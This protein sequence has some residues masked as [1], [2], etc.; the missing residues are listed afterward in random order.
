MLGESLGSVVEHS[1]YVYEFLHSNPETAGN[2]F[3]TAA[4]FAMELRGAG[5]EVTEFIGGLGV[6]GVLH[7]GSGPKILIRAELDGLA[8]SDATEQDFAS[9]QGVPTADCTPS[10][11][12]HSC[13]HDIHMAAAV[14]AARYLAGRRDSW[15]GTLIFTGQPAEETL[16][17][18]HRLL[19][20]ATVI[21]SAD[22]AL[23]QHVTPLP[24]GIVTL[25]DGQLTA[26]NQDVEVLIFSRDGHNAY[27]NANPSAIDLL[28][29][30]L[31]CILVTA[32][33]GHRPSH[34]LSVGEIHGGTSP[35]TRPTQVRVLL[36][37][38]ATEMEQIEQGIADLKERLLDSGLPVSVRRGNITPPVVNDHDL[39]TE[40]R[41]SFEATFGHA[42][43]V[44]GQPSMV[45]DDF[46]LFY[47]EA[48][49]PSVMWM[50]G[51]TSVGT[52]N[53]L[54]GR[55][56]RE[57]L[58]NAPTNHESD[59]LPDPPATLKI[60]IA[61]LCSAVQSFA[62]HLVDGPHL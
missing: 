7:N 38:R 41:S 23:T 33:P 35:H 58:A 51:G 45:V 54:T 10:S 13:G 44:A 62:P 6:I 22:I 50:V 4:R 3:L 27:T 12:I 20:E 29:A 40:L 2:E 39:T 52:W 17:G 47:S 61:A 37:I 26:W 1:A 9:D 55:T 18:A 25:T 59:F 43:V 30:V 34:L 21:G 11:A 15:S 60:C 5:C 42:Q 31:R 19:A 53:K 36:S 49:I 46:S 57:K 24:V 16:E 14:G 28:P 48:H 32:S 8:T 56:F